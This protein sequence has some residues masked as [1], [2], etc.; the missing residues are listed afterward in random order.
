LP[1]AYEVAAI[2]V[3]SASPVSTLARRAVSPVE[4]VTVARARAEE[5]GAIG[6]G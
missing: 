4:V 5:A 6:T 2:S 3:K 1:P